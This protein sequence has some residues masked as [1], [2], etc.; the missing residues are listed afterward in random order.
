MKAIILAAGRGSR[1]KDL[2]D[3]RPKCMVELD[4]ETLL[5]RQIR[6][7]RSSGAGEIAVVTGYRRDMLADQADREFHNP[8]WA[9][10]NMV[11]SLATAAEWLQQAPCIISYSDIFYGADAVRQ[12]S[13]SYAPLAI[14]YDPN[15][16]DLWT[17]R[18]GDPLLDAETFRI[19]A[20]GNILEIG[21]RPSKLDEI[22]GQFMGLLRFTPEAWHELDTMRMKMSDDARDK[23]DMTGALQRIIEHGN[24]GVKGI[25]LSGDWGEVDSADDLRVY[26]SALS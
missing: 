23:L 2:T 1:M 12:L 13:D 14:T 21:K 16:Q 10:T 3:D 26:Q 11:S 18:F 24:L 20:D 6:T 25:R 5:S 8:R 22:E 7:L 17:R 9:E 15:W 19:A 4:G